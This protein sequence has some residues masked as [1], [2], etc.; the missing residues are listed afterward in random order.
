[1]PTF[2]YQDFELEWAC[3]IPVNA[4][5]TSLEKKE[6]SLKSNLLLLQVGALSYQWF[7]GVPMLPT[8]TPNPSNMEILPT[9]SMPNPS[10]MEILPT[11]SM[12]NPSSMAQ[13]LQAE[14]AVFSVLLLVAE[15]YLIGVR[16]KAV[17]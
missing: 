7:L 3:H 10:N 9:G 1:M 6:Y 14:S 8:P 15:S 13:I 4:T 5:P 16:L 12:P 2:F 17:L 11:G